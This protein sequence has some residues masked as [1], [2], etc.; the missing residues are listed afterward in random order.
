MR[1]LLV[2]NH[3]SY[4]FNLFQLI[5]EV[6]GVDPVVVTNDTPMLKTLRQGG[7]DNIVISPGPGRPQESRDL[8]HVP[9]LLR[10]TDLPVLGV[11]LGHQAIAHAAGAAVVP[12]PRPRHG[13][14]ARV[15]H[16]G[17]AL[18]AGIPAE[19][20]A[21]RYHSLCVEEPLPPELEVTARAD[22]GVVMALRHRELPRW[23]VQFH[24]ESIASEYGREILTNFRDL[25][26]GAR[27]EARHTART[28]RPAR[29]LRRPADAPAYQLITTVLPRAVDT[30]AAFTTLYDRSSHCFW[31]D[32]SRVEEGLSRFS[33]LGD[34]TGP[35]SEVLTYGLSAGAVKIQDAKGL[36]L[37]SGSIFEVLDARLRQRRLDAPDLPFDL[38]GGY[39]GY[40]GYELKADCGAA[41]RHTADTPDAAW[42][43]ADRLI[44]VDHLEDRTYVIAVHTDDEQETIGAKEWVEA[45][46]ERL[47]ALEPLP[48][49][50]ALRTW[51]P[52]AQAPDATPFL[53]RDR[54]RY[55]ADIEECN[56]QLVRGE[57]YEVCVTNK[58]RLPFADDDL[59]FYRRLR[60][61]NPA[62]YAALLRLGDTTVF[63]SS[64]ERFLRID[65]AGT[66][67]SKPIKGTAPR[68]PDPVRDRA[69]A[70]ELA[71]SAKTQAENLMI[72]DLL[73]NDL[74]QVCEIGSVKVD[75]YMAVESYATVHQLVSTIQGRLTPSV[76]AVDC[77]RHCFPG[78][79]MTGAPKLR[80]ME[81]IDRLET[82][83]RGI[84]SGS[85]GYFG[86]SG[87]TDLNIVIRTAV[88]KGDE[89]TIGAGGAI[90]LDS[91]PQDEYEEML[92]KATAP[93]RA[94][95]AGR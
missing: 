69:L 37:E 27:D 26:H 73:R 86:L 92:L 16:D 28:S 6:N 50:E 11:C 89:L 35:L 17:D 83:A 81:I 33:F 78:G 64:P 52:P 15:T 67:E 3:D 46:A 18:F 95:Q 20:T 2:D 61:A 70:D 22:D 48:D 74:G 21:V 57:S 42:M 88:R 82:E 25:T 59:A 34:A 4:T 60:R 8:G 66:V 49:D 31:L 91:D 1:T 12:A 39:V 19:F 76:S 68:D 63:S 75:R 55:K 24:P 45:T 36:R 56:R 71:A 23:G 87:G 84:Y 40:F 14:L 58:L 47:A 10:H 94:W 5:A 93:L 29:P 41:K 65:R 62:P 32:S 43:F 13:H 38:T 9:D 85:L 72:V 80:T 51:Q 30:E 77:V 54:D 7:F 79:S 90:V 53:I 44:A